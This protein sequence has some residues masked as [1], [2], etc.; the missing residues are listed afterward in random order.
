MT[1]MSGSK[2]SMIS[3]ALSTS[4]SPSSSRRGRVARARLYSAQTGLAR[5]RQSPEVRLGL[6]QSHR[7]QAP[8]ARRVIGLRLEEV[9]LL[10]GLPEVLLPERSVKC[11]GC[12]ASFMLLADQPSCT[13]ASSLPC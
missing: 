5:R 4:A 13:A 3:R 9:R 1:H 12:V 6:G 10:V 7:V 11:W 2:C 8:G